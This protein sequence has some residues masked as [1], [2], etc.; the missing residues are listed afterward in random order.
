MSYADHRKLDLF[1]AKKTTSTG[2]NGI[3][4]CNKILSCYRELQ[5]RFCIFSKTEFE[6]LH[7]GLWV[8]LNIILFHDF[9]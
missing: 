7:A 4:I 1:V 8:S 9:N 3:E 2:K 6:S 5:N